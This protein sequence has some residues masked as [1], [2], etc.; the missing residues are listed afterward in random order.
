LRRGSCNLHHVDSNFNSLL[1]LAVLVDRLDIV[2]FLVGQGVQMN[3][4]VSSW[5]SIM[6]FFVQCCLLHCDRV[7]LFGPSDP[8]AHC[9]PARGCRNCRLSDQTRGRRNGDG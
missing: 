3:S 7:F 5:L 4:S 2:R 1:H 8:S 9:C 6:S